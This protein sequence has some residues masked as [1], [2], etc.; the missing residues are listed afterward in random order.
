MHSRISISRGRRLKIIARIYR[1]LLSAALKQRQTR[2]TTMIAFGDNLTLSSRAWRA[3]E[4]VQ[5]NSFDANWNREL[6][7][8][9]F[10]EAAL[11]YV[12]Q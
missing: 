11:A 7:Y 4:G 6:R 8:R 10:L 5:L 2:L 12:L 9:G 1:I 3:A